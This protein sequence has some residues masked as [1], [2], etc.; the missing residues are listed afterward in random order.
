[1]LAKKCFA[2]LALTGIFMSA[3]PAAIAQRPN[4][5]AQLGNRTLYIN[6]NGAEGTLKISVLTPIS[7]G[8]KFTARLTMRGETTDQ[9]VDGRCRNRNVTFTRRR[10]GWTQ[11]YNGWVF[12]RGAYSIAGT[13]S[14]NGSLQ[15]GWYA[16]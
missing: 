15:Y 6:G 1:M 3:V 11:R 16:K 14:H 8:Y 13:F 2:F 5:C 7:P 10:S 9:I 4:S 12:E